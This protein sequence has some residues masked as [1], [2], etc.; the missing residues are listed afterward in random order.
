MFYY[1][2]DIPDLQMQSLPGLKPTQLSLRLPDQPLEWAGGPT[3]KMAFFY[4]PVLKL[5]RDSSK[6]F[7]V[8]SGTRHKPL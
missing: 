6:R 8:F 4:L 3:I 1:R 2:Q 7:L 5:F